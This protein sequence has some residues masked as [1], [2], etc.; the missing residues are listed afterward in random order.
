MFCLF[1]GLIAETFVTAST[2]PAHI[3]RD[4]FIVPFNV[5][6]YGTFDLVAREILVRR[7]AGLASALLLGA[8]Y[9]FI[10]EGVVAGTWY[11]VHPQGYIFLGG[12]D[13]TWALTLTI[14]HAI[15][16]VFTPIAFIEI[17][18]PSIRGRSLLR[19]W[20]MV[21][22][23]VLLFAG[24]VV[25]IVVLAP[26]PLPLFFYRLTVLAIAVGFSLMALA[27]SFRQTAGATMIPPYTP[28][29][30]TSAPPT[31]TSLRPL[32]GLWHLRIAG[33]VAIFAFFFLTHLFPVVVATLLQ[34]WPD[35]LVIAQGVD[36][37]MLLAFSTLVIGRGWTWAQRALWSPRQNLALLLGGVTFTTLL[38][39]LTEAPMGELFSTLPFY[40]LL[41][42]LTLQWRHR[43]TAPRSPAINS[44]V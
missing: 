4:P 35:G 17:L 8:A 11:V 14:F 20:G 10:N 25:A 2:S 30:H 19:Q 43:E 31:A 5:V 41:I 15:I 21:S 13:W 3:L 37:V 1:A 23:V 33:F 16:S 18:F 32:P 22:C 42:A 34:A 6:L 28:L 12:V 26:L 29:L 9:G 27:L 39:N 40:V 7:K 24:I 44:I 38:L 36:C